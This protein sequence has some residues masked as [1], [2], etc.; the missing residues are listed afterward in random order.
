MVA[1]VG[2]FTPTRV[3]EHVIDQIGGTGV[4]S[5]ASQVPGGSITEHRVRVLFSREVSR[6]T[7]RFS[8]AHSK[9]VGELSNSAT[10]EWTDRGAIADGRDQSRWFV[11]VQEVASVCWSVHIGEEIARP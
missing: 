11:K 3:R 6:S 1:P 2:P 10:V 4:A 9:V 5:G 7:V 8:T